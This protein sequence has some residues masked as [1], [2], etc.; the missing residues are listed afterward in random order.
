MIISAAK[1]LVS[2]VE[3]IV[4]SLEKSVFV[5]DTIVPITNIIASWIPTIES[6]P[7]MIVCEPSLTGMRLEIIALLPGTIICNTETIAS[8]TQIIISW[9]PSAIR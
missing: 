5:A 3:L 2:K 6:G 4:S 9:R 7:E 1:T 8:G